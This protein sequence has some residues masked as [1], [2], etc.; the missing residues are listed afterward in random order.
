LR[1][2]TGVI[3]V[4]IGSGWVTADVGEAVTVEGLVEDNMGRYKSRYVSGNQTVHCMSG[5][6]SK[7]RCR[8]PVLINIGLP[9]ATR[10][11][12]RITN[13]DRIILPFAR[14]V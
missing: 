11:Q 9:V 14:T 10:R 4:Y 3:E 6:G 8:A 7:S 5:K 12:V 13:R 1:D 2:S